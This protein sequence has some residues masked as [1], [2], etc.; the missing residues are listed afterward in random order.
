MCKRKSKTPVHNLVKKLLYCNFTGN[1]CTKYGL[2]EEENAILEYK[3]FK[4]KENINVE[5]KKSGLVVSETHQFLGGSPDGIVDILEDGN[6]V[7]TGILEV[8]HVLINKDINFKQAA[9]KKLSSFCLTLNKDQNLKLKNSHNFFYQCQGLIHICDLP[10][11]D[12][13]FRHKN[14]SDIY[15]ERIYRDTLLWETTILPKLK[16]FFNKAILPELALP[17]FKTTGIIR[18]PKVCLTHVPIL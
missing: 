4:S 7:E 10:W 2:Q 13:I 16:Y 5:V 9:E 3:L 12:I 18:E 17:R 1:E 15:I 8:K 14:P 11:C 6:I